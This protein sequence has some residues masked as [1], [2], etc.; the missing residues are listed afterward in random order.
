VRYRKWA[1]AYCAKRPTS[2]DRQLIFCDPL[3]L[4]TREGEEIKVVFAMAAIATFALPSQGSAQEACKKSKSC[5]ESLGYCVEYRTRKGI[6]K[7]ELPCERS[8]AVCNKTGVWR[9]KY[10]RGTPEVNACRIF[11]PKG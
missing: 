2:Q 1:A 4:K 6:S 8:L 11:T 10:M 5:Q 3:V 7:A 9:G